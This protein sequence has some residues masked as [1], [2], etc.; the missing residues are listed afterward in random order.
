MSRSLIEI[1]GVG[2]YTDGEYLEDMASIW[3][4]RDWAKY[5]VSLRNPYPC[6]Y[7]I[8]II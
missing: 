4:L 6:L 8:A 2:I 1:T 3:K 5:K 7:W